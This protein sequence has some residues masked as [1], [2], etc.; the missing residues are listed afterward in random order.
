MAAVRAL[1][2][3]LARPVP[4]PVPVGEPRQAAVRQV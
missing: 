4:V 3:A 2:L 1:G